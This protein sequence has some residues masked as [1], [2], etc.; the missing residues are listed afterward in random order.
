MTDGIGNRSGWRRQAQLGVAIAT[1]VAGIVVFA[2]GAARI[3][4]DAL[5]EAGLSAGLA[6]EGAAA[7]AAALPVVIVVAVLATVD[8]EHRFQQFA[9]GGGVL[10]LGGIT[11]AV[12]ST[13]PLTD[14]VA[15]GLYGGGVAI[16]LGTLVAGVLDS[17]AS[18]TGRDRSNVVYVD[19]RS[20]DHVMPSDGGEEDDDLEFPL[21][22]EK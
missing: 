18:A 5:R 9:I 20:I 22:D 7:G 16:L 15:I 1:L 13:A 21:D 8:A 10:V 14:P 12:T 11:V 17:S 3:G 4:A 6:V 2:S 19:R